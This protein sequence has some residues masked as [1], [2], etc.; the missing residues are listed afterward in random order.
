MFEEMKFAALLQ[1]VHNLNAT[2]LPANQI[3][4]IATEKAANTF[5]INSGKIEENK[6]ADFILVDLKNIDLFPDHNL[7]SNIVYSARG[8]CVTHTICNGKI[9][10]NDKIIENE[11]KILD[12]AQEIINKIP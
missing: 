1:K 10:M 6:L 7:I 11:E 9:L 8:D 4:S 2:L 12:E 5:K 3:H